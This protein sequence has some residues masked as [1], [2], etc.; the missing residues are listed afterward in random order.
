MQICPCS[1]AESSNHT[2][3]KRVLSPGVYAVIS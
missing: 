2:Y 3:E 1:C